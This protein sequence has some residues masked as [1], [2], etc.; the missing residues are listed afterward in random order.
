MQSLNVLYGVVGQGMGHAT[1]SAVVIDKLARDG[2]QINVVSSG[3]AFT[4]LCA[5]LS[6]FHNVNI[7]EIS[8]FELVFREEKISVSR[9][10]LRL[11]QNAGNQLEQNYR[12]YHKM[13]SAN[14]RPDVVFSDFESWTFLFAKRHG[15]PLI[16]LDNMQIINRGTHNDV[17]NQANQ[18]EYKLAKRTVKIKN[19]GAYH[20]LVTSF[21]STE[22]R[23]KRTTIVPPII[24]PEILNSTPDRGSHFLVYQSGPLR[25]NLV[26]I[27]K[28][29]PQSFVLYGYNEE[30]KDGN[31]Q[32]RRFN[33]EQFFTDLVSSR[34][35]LAGGGFSLM[36]EAISLRIPVLAFPIAK[37]FEQELNAHYLKK[38][39]YGDWAHQPSKA[40]IVR[41]INQLGTFR[42]QLQEVEH[43]HNKMTFQCID[44]LLEDIKMNRYAPSFLGSPSIATYDPLD[45]CA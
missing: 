4:Y 19:P 1:R 36:S 35:V 31:L 30:K 17:I 34:G 45:K 40:T 38:L 12:V 29:L 9:T 25:E 18:Q 41:F 43:D 21:F 2:H 28:S 14:F 5:K 13:L 10:F 16:S 42:R 33:E 3:A 39:G 8:G 6:H 7:E 27:L 20:Y 24:R 26:E 22:I 23:K 37:H 32:F 15:L 44:E 11:L